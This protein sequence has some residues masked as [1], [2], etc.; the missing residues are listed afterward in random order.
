MCVCLV[1]FVLFC[2]SFRKCVAVLRVRFSNTVFVLL[3]LRY[4]CVLV[5]FGCLFLLPCL[6]FRVY[7]FCVGRCVSGFV[8]TASSCFL[9]AGLFC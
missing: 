4:S 9:L 2:A 8:M 6:S 5:C 3:F 7:L 1:F